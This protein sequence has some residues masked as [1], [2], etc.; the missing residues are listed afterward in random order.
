MEALAA[1]LLI[2][3]VWSIGVV[4]LVGLG[5]LI[6]PRLP[7]LHA[8]WT[9]TA[10]TIL[11][12]EIW[13]F[14]LPV[15]VL[16]G[17]ILL[18]LGGVGW[19]RSR[20]RI[21]ISSGKPLI[22]PA[23]FI[24]FLANIAIQPSTN[25][26]DGLYHFQSVLWANQYPVI[27]GL[28]N[29]HTRL[30]YNSTYY[31]LA[32]LFEPL[33]GGAEHYTA[34]IFTVA[35][36][37]AI[38][39]AYQRIR[40]GNARESDWLQIL[41]IVPLMMWFLQGDVSGLSNDYIL[42]LLGITL[43]VL[44]FSIVE[45]RQTMPHEMFVIIIL[46]ALGVSLKLSGLVLGACAVVLALRFYPLSRRAIN[47]FVFSVL[48]A[49]LLFGLWIARNVVLSGYPFYISTTLPMN[50]EWRVPA[51]IAAGDA[52]AALGWARQPGEN[53][54]SAVTGWSWIPAWWQR[55]LHNP[56]FLVPLLTIL[57]SGVIWLLRSVR[58]WRVLRNFGLYFLVNGIALGAW[59]L[60]APDTRF[61]M[62]A[63]WGLSL[64]VLTLVTVYHRH[65]SRIV[66]IY[67]AILI[68]PTMFG[69]LAHVQ[70]SGFQPHEQPVEMVTLS[71]GFQ[72]YVPQPVDGIQTNQCW[73]IPLP[74]TPFYFGENFRLRVPGDLS[75]GF[76]YHDPAAPQ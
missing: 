16:P 74:C 13:N 67:I 11:F 9:G 40:Q 51:E 25:F 73:R 65:R 44:L 28:A 20:P 49:G 69:L 6:V 53:Y 21:R 42:F 36:I 47:W 4:T 66:F 71:S 32:A 50:A 10:F 43:A 34:G 12:L 7:W 58:P 23:L 46:A 63:L 75:S 59:F 14:V 56:D 1:T 33:P 27:P 64:G 19:L 45:R 62:S 41:F 68:F 52:E 18:L 35:A 37:L 31:I 15:G 26:D 5:R 60:S 30:A 29:L 8:F 54:R 39:W 72:V 17:A 24:L 55:Q 61:A 22:L 48:C 3:A 38:W 57:M 2:A 70:F 76:E